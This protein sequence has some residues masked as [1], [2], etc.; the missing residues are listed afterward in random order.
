MESYVKLTKEKHWGVIEECKN[1][2]I[3]SLLEDL[4]IF[5]E[6]FVSVD[7]LRKTG[8]YSLFE[9]NRYGIK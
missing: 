9:E 7:Y 4:S 5:A 6:V 2:E 3:Y 1:P 8:L